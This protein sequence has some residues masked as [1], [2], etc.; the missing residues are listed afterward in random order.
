MSFCSL[1]K[2]I[3]PK[4]C[5]VCFVLKNCILFSLLYNM[6]GFCFRMLAVILVSELFGGVAGG[7]EGG[8]ES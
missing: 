4:I 2:G 7:R 8:R 5:R 1:I 6:F 3:T